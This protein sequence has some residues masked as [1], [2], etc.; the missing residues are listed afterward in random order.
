MA[1]CLQSWRH[2]VEGCP[3]GVVILT[4]HQTL[5][6]IMDQPVL[7]KVQNRWMR[8]GLFQSIHPTIKYHPGKANIIADAL[9]RS[10][11]KPME[12]EEPKVPEEEGNLFVLSSHMEM[13]QEERQKWITA[14]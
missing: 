14:I 1:Y 12:A 2:Y 6:R 9:S 10:Q 7:T 3:G 8:L 11:R 13:D 5:N 4:D